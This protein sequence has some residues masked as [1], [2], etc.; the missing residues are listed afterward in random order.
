MAALRPGKAGEAVVRFAGISDRNKAE[1]LKGQSLYV[2]RSALPAPNERE[3]YLADL[4]GLRAE[5]ARGKLLGVVKAVHNFGAGDV[6]EIELTDSK[7]EFVAFT[8][9]NVPEVDIAG[10]RFVIVPPSYAEDDE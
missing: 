3:F 9:T 1:A 2:P 7:T 6:L 4:I 8:D 5:D 10:G